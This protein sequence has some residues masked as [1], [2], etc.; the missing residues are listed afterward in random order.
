MKFLKIFFAVAMLSICTVKLSAQ[1]PNFGTTVGDQKLYGYSSL[2]YRANANTWETYSTLQFGITDYFQAGVDLYT[3]TNQSY[4]GYTVRGGY[5]FCDYFKLGAQI[6]PSFDLNDKH[7]FAYLTSAIYINGN[8]TKD[9]RLFYVTDTWLE[10]DKERLTSAKQW[11]YLGYTI[12]IGKSGN[13]SITPLAGV[14]HSWRFDQP[15]DLSFGFYFTHKNINLYAWTNDIL[16]K[17]PRF[18]LA[19]E[20]AFGNK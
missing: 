6:T 4:I 9:G 17:Q 19:V 14:I 11:T 3:A 7:Q 1:V 13:N 20:F 10:N 12:P 18:I 5:K 2:K 16:T 8:I 15:A